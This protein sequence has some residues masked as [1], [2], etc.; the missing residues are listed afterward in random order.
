[1]ATAAE[2][3]RWRAK[4]RR[5]QRLAASDQRALTRE[6][7]TAA[8]A[9][10]RAQ[11]GAVARGLALRVA[12]LLDATEEA[13]EPGQAALRRL[14]SSMGLTLDGADEDAQRST[15][16]D[17]LDRAVEELQN[18]TATVASVRSGLQA[19][20]ALAKAR[21][22]VNVAALDGT[23]R[24]ALAGIYTDDS[25]NHDHREAPPWACCPGS[26]RRSREANE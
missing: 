8:L 4:Q 7:A 18:G 3:R 23:I 19:A 14:A 12:G 9:W 1:M 6:F 25:V 10:A 21:A 13:E 16:L 15:A 20:S 22:R 17:M 26:R 5:K 11:D 24:L 2:Q